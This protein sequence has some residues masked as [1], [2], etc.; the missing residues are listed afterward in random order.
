MAPDDGSGSCGPFDLF[1]P[2][3]ED[4]VVVVRRLGVVVHGDARPGRTEGEKQTAATR[5]QRT[6]LVSYL[7]LA[8]SLTIR[9]AVSIRVAVVPPANKNVLFFAGWGKT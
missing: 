8:L 4:L 9:I 3:S 1:F 7:A 6:A 2:F 5:R